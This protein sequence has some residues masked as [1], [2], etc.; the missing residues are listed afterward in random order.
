MNFHINL[1]VNFI[2]YVKTSYNM[3]HLYKFTEKIIIDKLYGKTNIW[4]NHIQH[5]FIWLL[6]KI[7]T[8]DVKFFFFW[9]K[10]IKTKLN[11]NIKVLACTWT[12]DN[13]H[14]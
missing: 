14:D 13:G 9:N 6:G 7:F 4:N 1:V 2:G 5:K 10:W 8:R 12:L 3:K 11:N